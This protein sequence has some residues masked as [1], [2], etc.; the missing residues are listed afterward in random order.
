MIVVPNEH[1]ENMYGLEPALAGV[2]PRG[3]AS[4]RARPTTRRT[5]ARASRTRQ[6][7]EPAGYQEVWHYHLHVF[8]RWAGDDLYGSPLARHDADANVDRTPTA[9]AR[10]FSQRP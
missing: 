6:H 4:H 5:G 8:P 9:S 3:C 7:N 10:R 1:V 2:D